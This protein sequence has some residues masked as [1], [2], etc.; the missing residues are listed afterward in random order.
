[1]EHYGAGQGVPMYDGPA[2][3]KS[4]KDYGGTRNQD[5]MNAIGNLQAVTTPKEPGLCE[6]VK[7]LRQRVDSLH[8]SL[9]PLEVALVRVIGGF[10]GSAGS[11]AEK[12]KEPESID[13][14][15]RLLL[16]SL[17]ELEGRI[18]ILGH[19]FNDRL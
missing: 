1:M 16:Q 5:M 2:I 8:S 9:G 15:L 6:V 11:L 18:N 14:Q 17:A 13:A 12:V 7:M 4:T 19:Q 3:A 10:T